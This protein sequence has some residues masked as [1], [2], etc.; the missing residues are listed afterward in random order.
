MY[1]QIISQYN[2]ILCSMKNKTVLSLLL[3]IFS[4]ALFLCWDF[5]TI[6][7]C[8]VGF[9]TFFGFWSIMIVIT[10]LGNLYISKF[11]FC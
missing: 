2:T 11:N 3:S 10:I 1:E 5:L 7:Y 6:I 8:V 9:L 4:I